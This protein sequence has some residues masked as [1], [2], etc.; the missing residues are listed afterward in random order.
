MNDEWYTPDY[1]LDAARLTLGGFDLDPYSCA[2]ANERVKAATYFTQGMDETLKRTWNG[3]VWMNPPFSRGK[4]MPAVTKLVTEWFQG[5]IT[6]VVLT[7]TCTET[8]WFQVL[9]SAARAVCF[10]AARIAFHA[11]GGKKGDQPR[12]GHALFYFGSN[13]S[14]FEREFMKLGKVVFL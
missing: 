11:P 5:R 9:L 3:R 1:V 14:R 8:A 6:A 4:I 12:Q 7:N 13:P 10:P 2:E